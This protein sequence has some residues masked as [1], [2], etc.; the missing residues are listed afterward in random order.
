MT[1]P[2]GAASARCSNCGRPYKSSACGFSHATI[3]AE[4]ST[5]ARELLT[6]PRAEARA[7]IERV[8]AKIVG[9]RSF[10]YLGAVAFEAPALIA[11]LEAVLEREAAALI[12]VETFRPDHE[13]TQRQH[14]LIRDLQ[15]ENERQRE[16]LTDICNDSS[17]SE[18]VLRRASKALEP[19]P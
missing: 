15:A 10:H 16:A 5:S 17:I 7:L 12:E 19:K 14:H 13:R 2:S 6:D 8:K 1:D 11:A 18:W 3:Q 9:T 4:R